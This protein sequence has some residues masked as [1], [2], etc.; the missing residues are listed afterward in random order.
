M[1]L[2]LQNLKEGRL[3]RAFAIGPDHPV[4]RGL[5]GEVREP[6]SLDVE[7]TNPAAGTYVM[8]AELSGEVIEP[9]RRCL[10]PAEVELD[11]RFR[12]VYR[13]RARDLEDEET[14]DEDLVLIERGEN[15]I[16]IDGEVR[17]RLFLETDR[18]PLCR[19]DCE[20]I[21]P[22]CGQNRNA[23]SCDCELDEVDSRWKALEELRAGME[24]G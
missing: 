18:Y 14:G 20:G 24:S 10:E 17:D 5:D 7:L 9:C 12:M 22:K 3:R 13:E 23:G 4:V 1:K 11:E 6:L 2:D 15:E 21:C 16:E 19:P 8:T